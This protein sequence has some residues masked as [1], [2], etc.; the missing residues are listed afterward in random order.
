MGSTA[1]MTA[2]RNNSWHR[3]HYAAVWLTAVVLASCAG[4]SEPEIA[5]TELGD[6]NNY[7]AVS[8]LNLPATIETAPSDLEICWQNVTTDIRCHDV[9]PKKGINNVTLLR[10]ENKSEADVE[11][12]L[13][14]G[15]IPIN[16]LDAYFEYE[17]PKDTASRTA[18]ASLSE[19]SRVGNAIDIS[20][21][22]IESDSYTYLLVFA[23]GS[24]PG[25]Q[26]VTMT[27]VTPKAD[28]TN[29]MVNAPDNAALN[30]PTGCGSLTFTADIVS[31]KALE[32]PAEGPWSL[33]WTKVTL[34]GNG[35]PLSFGSVDGL[36]LAFYEDMTAAD[37]EENIL[38]LEELATKLWESDLY[39]ETEAD[40]ADLKERGTGKAFTGFDLKANG[41]WAL[42]MLCSTCQN[43]APLILTIVEPK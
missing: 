13:G 37:L 3:G 17:P 27:F 5:V 30:Q 28:S 41:V 18:C 36:M 42:A 29:T 31:A 20:K 40:L 14:A 24:N 7:Q 16:K 33:D 35:N 8:V 26:T 4:K 34:D 39:G 32:V 38:D 11:E 22:Y 10:F 12:L 9:D 2:A 23:Q 43:P 6:S 25:V 19:F 15:E 1:G 21:E